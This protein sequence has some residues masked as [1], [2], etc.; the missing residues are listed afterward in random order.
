MNPGKTMNF[1]NHELF[2]IFH[3][4]ERWEFNFDTEF[5]KKFNNFILQNPGL[6]ALEYSKSIDFFDFTPESIVKAFKLFNTYQC[7]FHR[8]CGPFMFSNG[9]W[10]GTDKND[11]YDNISLMAENK[12]LSEENKYLRRKIDEIVKKSMDF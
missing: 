3:R 7:T 8:I 2:P 6:S 1:N 11:K 12:K 9:K 10:Y 5:Y 4:N